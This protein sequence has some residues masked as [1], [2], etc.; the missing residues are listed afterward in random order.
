MSSRRWLWRSVRPGLKAVGVG[1][2]SIVEFATG[3]VVSSVNVPLADV[4]LRHVL[5]DRL[6]VPV[7]VDNDATVAALAEAFDEQLRLVATNLVMLT[8]GTGVG[9]GLVLGGRIYRGSTGG[10]GELG[11]TI[12]GLM[13]AVRSR[14]R[15]RFPQPGSLEALASGHALDRLAAEAAGPTPIPYSGGCTPRARRWSGRMSCRLPGRATRR[16]RGMVELWAERVGI[17]DGQRDQH[18]RS[19]RGR[20]R[21]RSRRGRRSAAGARDTGRARLHRARARGAHDDPHGPPRRGG[22]CARRRAAGRAGARQAS[23]RRPDRPQVVSSEST[24]VWRVIVACGFD[25]AGLPLRGR[26]LKLIED[27]GHEVLD[28]GTD[29]TRAGR[30]PRKGAGGGAR[31]RFRPGRAR[32]PR[33]RLGRRGVGGGVQDPGDL[34][35]HDP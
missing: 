9:G 15:W 28:L 20:D 5:S 23:C 34:R 1:V 11:H 32:D 35:G 31:G 12:V 6:G 7:F 24:E 8:I 30:L 18:V 3:R 33:V 13:R 27:P 26:L 4:A 16:R 29:S 19:R 17:G 22:R 25:H 21:R 14:R 10:A 2:P